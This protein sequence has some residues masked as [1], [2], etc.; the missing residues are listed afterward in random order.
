[1]NNL[2]EH[3]RV[4][5]ETSFHLRDMALFWQM[6]T[7][8][9][10]TTIE[11]IR[12]KYAARGELMKTL[13]F[14]PSI[15]CDNWK[16]EWQKYSKVPEKDIVVL[17]KSQV[18]RRK[19]ML[20]T[21]G[22]AL[23]NA[24]ILITNYEAVEMQDLFLM[25]KHW[26]PDILVADES[27]R[28]KSPTSKRAKKVL[29][30]ASATRHNYILTG[31]PVL[32]TPLDL[33][34]QFC[35]LDRGETFGRNFFAFRAAYFEDEN[36]RWKGKQNY[37]PKWRIKPQAAVEIQ[38]KIKLKAMRVVKSECLTLP[39]FV[40]QKTFTELSKEQIKA[41]KEMYHDY[42]TFVEKVGEKP[43]P[44]VAQLAVTKALR[45]QQIVSGFVKD[46]EGNIHRLECPRL[47]VLEE[48]LTD[49]TPNHKVIIW[50]EFKEN[51]KM[52]A[53]LCDSLE[54]Q[55]RE[56]HGDVPMNHRYNAM[57]EFRKDPGVRVMI[58]NQGAAGVGVNLV[59]ASYS[60]YYSK[61]FKLEHD[62]QSEAR[63]F[64][65]GSE[66]HEKVTRID[67]VARGTIDELVLEALH[68]KQ[69]ISERILSW[70]RELELK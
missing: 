44:V 28:L 12:R 65:G 4:A 58:A 49:L 9:T 70:K 42:V 60:I 63:N 19:K 61:G 29:E 3:Q 25:L 2:W 32:N 31:T 59:E 26:Q 50:S 68:N 23:E 39:P 46:D 7:G 15:V 34:M 48:L 14:C 1:M 5:V 33:F 27:Q 57:E 18:E 17:N 56:I 69:E 43:A 51:Q 47:K 24:K 22:D 41:Y 66:M 13:I 36:D 35:V 52:I 62:L 21:C 8:K 64:R 45:L 40:K 55:Y 10:R 54:I 6:G 38:D 37:F 11:I 20:K 67:I 16:D 53:E 30:L